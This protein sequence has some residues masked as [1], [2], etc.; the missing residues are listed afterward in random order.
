MLPGRHGNE[1]FGSDL[2][3]MAIW[4]K[5][6]PIAAFWGFKSISLSVLGLELQEQ[7]KGASR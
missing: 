4:H 6:C 7:I 2:A 1:T 3:S 5:L